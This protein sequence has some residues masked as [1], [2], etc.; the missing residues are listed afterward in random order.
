MKFGATFG[1]EDRYY[2]RF[3]NDLLEFHIDELTFEDQIKILSMMK[4]FDLLNVK[5]VTKFID[6]NKG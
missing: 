5:V 2:W 3:I 6:L 1:I 4:Q